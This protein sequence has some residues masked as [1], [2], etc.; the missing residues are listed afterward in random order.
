MAT[1]IIDY[2]DNNPLDSDELIT[3]YAIV[4]LERGLH[5][6]SAGPGH[7]RFERAVEAIAAARPDLYETATAVVGPRS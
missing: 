6:P 1:D 4:I 3:E 2:A 5:L 7:L